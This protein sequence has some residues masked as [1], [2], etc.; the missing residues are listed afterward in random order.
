MHL[1]VS[2]GCRWRILVVGPGAASGGGPG[3]EEK[4]DDNEKC[5]RVS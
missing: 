3:S 1:G 4:K 2:V 5:Q